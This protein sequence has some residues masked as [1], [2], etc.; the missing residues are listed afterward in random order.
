M[1][2][3][4]RMKHGHATPLLAA[5]CLQLVNPSPAAA[6]A[7]PA[8]DADGGLARRY[9]TGLPRA[10][11]ARLKQTGKPMGNILW[12]VVDA[13]RPDHMG[14]YGYAKPTTPFINQLASEGF[15]FLHHQ[16][17]APWTRPSTAS[18]LTGLFPSAHRTQTEQSRLPTGIRTLGQDL[19]DVGYQTAAVVANGN[20]SSV[21]GLDRG[22]DHY[23]DTT[24]AWKG[25]PD[26]K[27]VYSKG[28]EWFDQQRN[29]KEGAPWFMFMFL[30]DP[31]G[32]YHAPPE[33]E[34]RWLPTDFKGE[35]RRV[36]H[37]EYNNNYPQAER[38]SMLAIYD[39]S[40]R[41]TDDATRAFFADLSRRGLLDNTT[42][43]IT[44]DHGEGF[45]EH[46]YYLHAHHHYD[47]IVRVPLIIKSPAWSGG[48]YVFHSTHHVDMLPTLVAGAGGAPRA[49]LPGSNLAAL[50]QAPVDRNRMLLT[51]YNAFGIHRSSLVNQS[52][53]V[54][55]QL[56]ADE[57]EFLRHVP[58]RELLPSVNFT[59]P[60]L[61]IYNRQVDPLDRT[62]I[63]GS[64]PRAAT[65]MAESLRTYM[66]NA[67]AANREVDP[68]KVPPSV[69][70]DL[71]S[72]GYVQ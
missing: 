57:D 28:L 13:L 5:I 69:L 48:G 42:I 4:D 18:M 47:E 40:I 44:A 20:G 8:K 7:G 3:D 54:I 32:P 60:V 39:A 27:Q 68:A 53:R 29:P 25:L 15:V 11:P 24:T 50:L 55:L 65:M 43:I 31:H 41:Y 51:E 35:P 56:P 62:D 61:H 71:R 67:P 23:V 59:Q 30:V 49:G 14:C 6:A 17:N 45:G 33:Y 72:L 19:K 37:W 64:P 34:K 70:E 22:V 16:A 10:P 36:A 38:D 63:S 1:F 21:A 26:A 58:R 46:G 2:G 12:I 52:Y 66:Q 9:F